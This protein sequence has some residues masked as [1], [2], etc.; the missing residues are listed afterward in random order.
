[1]AK[2]KL[3]YSAVL[4]KRGTQSVIIAT[5]TNTA[6]VPAVAIHVQAFHAKDNERILPVFMNEN[7]FTLMK[8]ESKKVEIIFDTALLNDG[9]YTL[10]A[11]PYN[12]K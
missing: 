1:M 6:E 3:K 9:K 10:V 5:I 11:E 2:A 4:E 12:N 8:N 7:Y